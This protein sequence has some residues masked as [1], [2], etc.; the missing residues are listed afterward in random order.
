MSWPTETT[1]T[2]GASETRYGMTIYPA[3]ETLA[4]G[5]EKMFILRG[6]LYRTGSQNTI[7]GVGDGTNAV[8]MKIESNSNGGIAKYTG[9]SETFLRNE[10]FD[11]LHEGDGIIQID[12]LGVINTAS[13]LRLRGLFGTA[14]ITS[15]TAMLNYSDTSF[16]ATLTPFVAT[17]DISKCKLVSQLIG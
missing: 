2:F 13:S 1:H 9:G 15:A 14:P 4:G 11:G 6:L 7:M 12:L 16:A 10:G 8:F 3:N 17:N 5:L